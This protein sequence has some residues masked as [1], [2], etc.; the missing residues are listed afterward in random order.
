[1]DLV[2]FYDDYWRKKGDLFD[3][4]RLGQMASYIQPGERVLALDCGP[5]VLARLLVDRGA[6][7]VGVDMSHVAVQMAREKSIDAH[8][9]DLDVDPLPFPDDSFDTVLSDSGIEHRFHVDR[10]LDEAV[11][12]LRPGGRLII[13][14]P[15]LVHWRCRLWLLQGRFPMVPNSPTDPIHIRFFTMKEAKSLLDERSVRVERTDGTVCLWAWQF[16]PFYL[17]WPVVSTIY[18]WLAHRWPSLFARDIILF[19]RKER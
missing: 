19:G 3:N 7:V 11:R 13:S 12:V 10:S 5:G 15:N 9:V 14:L 17:R 2:A 4:E 18:T 1:M 8:Q 6:Q 16:Y